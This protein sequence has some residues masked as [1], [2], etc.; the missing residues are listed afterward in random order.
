MSGR[1]V[2]IKIGLG[3]GR[4]FPIERFNT[5]HLSRMVSAGLVE[6]V[7]EPEHEPV[8]E[9]TAKPEPIK[10]TRPAR[11]RRRRGR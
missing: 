3:K 7:E 9:T 11:G 10:E 1:R 4:E 8:V 5:H 2:R 6:I